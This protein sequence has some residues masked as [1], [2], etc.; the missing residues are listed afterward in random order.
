MKTACNRISGR[1]DKFNLPTLHVP[2]ER[3]GHLLRPVQDDLG[4]E[5]PGVYF[6]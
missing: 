1:L 6:V 5:V 4:L 3:N 2:T